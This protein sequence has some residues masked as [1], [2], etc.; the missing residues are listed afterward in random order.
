MQLG[1][2]AFVAT[3]AAAAAFALL[4]ADAQSAPRASAAATRCDV[5]NVARRLGPTYVTS[6]NVTG[7]RCASGISVVRAFHTCRLA[8]GVRGRCVRRVSGY[9]CSET[10][11]GISTQFSARVTCRKGRSKKVVHTYT[12]FT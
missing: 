12:Q 11:N 6:L 7:V 4:A 10:R 5:S 9:S 8:N 2:L 3:L 1:A